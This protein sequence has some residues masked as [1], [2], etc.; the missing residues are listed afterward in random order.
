[1]RQE[2]ILEADDAQSHSERPHFRFDGK[3]SPPWDMRS[4][5]TAASMQEV[6]SHP[7]PGIAVQAPSSFIQHSDDDTEDFADAASAA[8]SSSQVTTLYFSFRCSKAFACGRG[9]RHTTGRL[10]TDLPSRMLSSCG[11]GI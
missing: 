5:T 1:M 7:L 9:N 8:G 10:F 3:G 6:S 11:A 4:S 2:S